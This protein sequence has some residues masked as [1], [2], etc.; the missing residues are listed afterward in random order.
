MTPGKFSFADTVSN[1]LKASLI[2]S[3]SGALSAAITGKAG[4]SAAIDR[5]VSKTLSGS[6]DFELTVYTIDDI[7]AWPARLQA[8]AGQ[9]GEQKIIYSLSAL[10]LAGSGKQ[11]VKDTLKANLSAE[12]GAVLPGVADAG[13]SGSADIDNAS[14]TAVEATTPKQ[15]FVAALGFRN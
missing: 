14:N 5:A 4:V 6:Y 10:K 3:I 15:A 13:A 9:A 7:K 8:C 2:A 12:I 1:D 11:Q